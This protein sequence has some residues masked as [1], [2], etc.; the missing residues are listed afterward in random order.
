MAVPLAR[1]QAR[2]VRRRQDEFRRKI[3]VA[4]FAVIATATPSP[5][6]PRSSHWIQVRTCAH[7]GIDR[8]SSRAA[9]VDLPVVVAG[10]EGAAQHEFPDPCERAQ[11]RSPG[12]RISVPGIDDV[13]IGI[14]AICVRSIVLVAIVA[15]GD[16]VIARHPQLAVQHLVLRRIQ[17]ASG[18]MVR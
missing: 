5:P 15:V 10:R 7:Y 2:E 3:P 12:D 1:V 11:R 16:D 13:D 9:A 18:Q 8:I 6:L 17:S 14:V 4:V